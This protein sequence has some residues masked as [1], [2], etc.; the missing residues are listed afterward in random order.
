MD[1]DVPD[2]ARAVALLLHPHPDMGG[3][4]FNHVI[5]ALYRGLPAAGFGAARFDFTDADLERA[6]EATVAAIDELPSELPVALVGYSFGAMVAMGVDDPRVTGWFLVAPPVAHAD[7]SKLATDPRPKV[8]AAPALDQFT[9]PATVADVTAGWRATE[10]HELAGADHFL[11][12]STDEIVA[13][14]VD[15]LR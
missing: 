12:G 6:A 7:A 4:R 2:G 13:L 3:D 15:W 11:A 9:P 1:L 14:V 10:V 5:G 8:I